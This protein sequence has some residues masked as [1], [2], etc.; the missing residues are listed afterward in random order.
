M[1]KRLQHLWNNIIPPLL[2]FR[3]GGLKHLKKAKKAVQV[4]LVANRLL[5]TRPP[6]IFPLFRSPMDLTWNDLR[7]VFRMLTVM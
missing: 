6:R 3:D 1:N 2:S 4:T 5:Y 7:S